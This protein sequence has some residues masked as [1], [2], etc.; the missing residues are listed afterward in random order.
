MSF[1]FGVGDFLAV[2]K[3]ANDIRK[4]FADAP[5][6]FQQ[7]TAEVRNLA[8]VLG[9]VD[10]SLAAHDVS[11]D[12][13]KN[14]SEI[15][16]SCRSV[17]ED[18]HNELSKYISLESTGRSLHERT[19]RAWKRV[20]WEPDDIRD[21][22]G[23]VTANIVALNSFTG[24]NIRDTVFKLEERQ[25]RRENEETLEW[26]TTLDTTAQQTDSIRQRQTGTG[27]WLLDS[28]KYTKWKETKGDILFC[29][30]IPGAGKTVLSSIVVENLMLEL[31]IEAD[32]AICYFYFNFKREGEQTL[33]NVL[34][35][36]LKQLGYA[37]RS[38][39]DGIQAL[40]K[41]CK[42]TQRR[43]SREEIVKTIYSVAD[44]FSRVLIVLDAL[45]ECQTSNGCQRELISHLTEL[46]RTAGANILATS[47][48]VPHI[49]EK[50]KE[51]ESVEVLASEGDIRRYIESNLEQLPRFVSRDHNLQNEIKEGITKAVD[52]MFLLAKLHLDSLKGKKS[53][54]ALRQT[55]NT[56]AKG[57]DAYD[58][59]YQNTMLRIS[60]QLPDQKELAMSTLMWIVHAKRPLSTTELQH[61][62]GV[63][64]GEPEF[65]EDNLPDLDDMV[66]E[67]FDRHGDQ[68]FPDAE[69]Q[70]TDTC[71]TYLA[72]DYFENGPCHSIR[73]MLKDFPLYGYSSQFWG[74]HAYFHADSEFI[75]NFLNRPSQVEACGYYSGILEP[76]FI[77]G[78]HFW[79]QEEVTSKM[80]GLHLA[81]CYGLVNM[82]SRILNGSLDP[83]AQDSMCRTPLWYAAQNGHQDVVSQLLEITCGLDME[84]KFGTTPLQVAAGKGHE[85]VVGVLLNKGASM[86]HTDKSGRTPLW[87]AAYSGYEAVVRLLL[88][89]G[90]HFD[91]TNKDGETPLWRAALN[92]YEAV[93][94]LLLDKGAYIDHTDKHGQT[95]LLVAAKNGHKAVVRLLLAKGARF[96]YIHKYGETPLWVAANDGHEAVVRLLLDKGAYIDHMDKSGRTPLLVA[97][98]NGHEAVVRLLLDKGARFD[99]IEE[100]SET[101]LWVAADNGHEAVVRLLLDKGARFDYVNENGKTPL[102][103]AAKD[104]HEAMVRLLLDKGAHIDYA[105]KYGRTPLWRAAFQNQEPIVRLLL[106]NGAQVDH[107]HNDGSTPLWEAVRHGHQQVTKTLI[108]YGADTNSRLPKNGSTPLIHGAGSGSWQIVELLL[109]AKAD[110]KITDIYNRS[111]LMDAVI[112]NHPDVIDALLLHD[113]LDPNTRDFWGS[114]ALSFAARSGTLSVFR[115]IAALPNVDIFSQDCFGRTP[116]WWA[117][118]QRHNDIERE[119]IGHYRST[120]YDITDVHAPAVGE[121]VEF[122]DRGAYCDVCYAVLKGP[123][124]HCDYCAGGELDICQECHGLGARCLVER[125]QLSIKTKYDGRTAI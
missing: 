78:L 108:E 24:A 69:A 64:I 68:Y 84:D 86:D 110:P 37:S 92:N 23:R 25:A 21:L 60:G 81:A 34:L 40:V 17:L 82:I 49:V 27:Q 10:V 11:D 3:L 97:A 30:G 116:L 117:Q 9:D 103:W 2:I 65:F 111:A 61:A 41:Q 53:P 50:F 7:I 14:L 42:S 100:Y 121:P 55:L 105:D 106:D 124:F 99:Y 1:G 94:R 47:R 22:R 35:S 114:T 16:E 12:Q 74:Q 43:P 46:Q 56:L 38:V 51:F 57:N 83:D 71:V 63:E 104:G 8:I 48:P 119:V 113:G 59:A 109:D 72:F 90:A 120:N 115:Q 123:W 101:P 13:K 122:S 80:T 88:D 91:V 98:K 26:L 102:S 45:D 33:E 87:R 85:A 67:F 32:V 62:L 5:E 36:L 6:Q 76:P 15:R 29:H 70:L 58:E 96:D 52:G 28:P 44:S 112:Q 93:V 118:K 20:K 77:M 18:S 79:P 73:V 75:W 4:D 107:A 19:K 54:R 95:P 125:H 31:G 39:P 66:S 89:K